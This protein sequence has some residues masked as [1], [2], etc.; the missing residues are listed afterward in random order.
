MSTK[1]LYSEFNIPLGTYFPINLFKI[2][3]TVCI[4]SEVNTR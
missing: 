1:P 2:K 3:K 4:T